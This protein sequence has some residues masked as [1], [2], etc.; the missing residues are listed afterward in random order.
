MSAK[1]VLKQLPLKIVIAVVIVILYIWMYIRYSY[2]TGIQ[3]STAN[4][5]PEPARKFNVDPASDATRW[6][7]AKTGDSVKAGVKVSITIIEKPGYMDE[8]FTTFFR[9][10]PTIYLVVMCFLGIVSLLMTLQENDIMDILGNPSQVAHIPQACKSQKLIVLIISMSL[11]VIQL[12]IM[13]WLIMYPWKIKRLNKS[14]LGFDLN[15]RSSFQLLIICV[16]VLS[17]T[18][19]IIFL[20]LS[21]F[22]VP[23]FTACEHEVVYKTS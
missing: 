17:V 9:A 21:W 20:L 12:M 1:T 15:Y 18:M 3:T 2:S 7:E 14:E 5:T 6:L 22:N 19:Y 10:D 11:I 16:T 23:V 8:W 4:T 13:L